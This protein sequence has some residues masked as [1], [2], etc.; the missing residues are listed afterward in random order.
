M[1]TVFK[2]I[3]PGDRAVNPFTVPGT[4]RK[5][6]CAGGANILVPDY[7]ADLMTSSEGWVNS[8][9]KSTAGPTS[10]RPINPQI[11]MTFND[12]TIGAAVTYAGPKTGWL[13]HATGASA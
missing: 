10:A 5:Y 13:H 6:V 9:T 2:L 1:S 12:T 3:M 4:N 11:G 8:L 7:D